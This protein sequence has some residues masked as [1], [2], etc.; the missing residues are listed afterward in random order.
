MY[1]C[2]DADEDTVVSKWVNTQCGNNICCVTLLCVTCLCIPLNM[3]LCA[4]F[5]LGQCRHRSKPRPESLMPR[6]TETCPA[7]VRNSQ[8][9]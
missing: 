2:K 6:I 9:P 8:G 7:S 4:C 5:A 3:E 1:T